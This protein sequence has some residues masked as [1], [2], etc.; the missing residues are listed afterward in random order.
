MKSTE[1]DQ[2]WQWDPSV[3]PLMHLAMITDHVEHANDN[4]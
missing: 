4:L 2:Q 3:N 1:E